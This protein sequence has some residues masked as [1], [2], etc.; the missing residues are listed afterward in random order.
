MPLEESHVQHKIL[1]SMSSDEN[2]PLLL[3]LETKLGLFVVFILVSFMC[4]GYVFWIV[5]EK[6]REE[7]KRK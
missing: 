1:D 5:M 6:E 4:L 7:Q 2:S 3:S